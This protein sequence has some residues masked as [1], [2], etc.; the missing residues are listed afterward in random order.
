VNAKDAKEKTQDAKGIIR[1]RAQPIA[2]R[3]NNG[4]RKVVPTWRPFFF[5][6]VL[7]PALAFT[8]LVFL[9]FRGIKL[10]SFLS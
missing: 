4:G 1:S 6:C 3:A 9:R 10:P 2:A 5:L 8:L 7:I